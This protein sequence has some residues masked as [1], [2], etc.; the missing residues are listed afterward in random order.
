MPVRPK[1][2]TQDE[3]LGLFA[4]SQVGGNVVL[5]P[6]TMFDLV[7]REVVVGGAIAGMHAVTGDEQHDRVIDLGAGEE[8]LRVLDRV[9]R[10]DHVGAGLALHVQ[11]DSGHGVGPGGQPGVFG[12]VNDIGHVGQTHRG[13]VLER[14]DQV[15]VFSGFVH[16]Q[17]MAGGTLLEFILFLLLG[18]QTYGAPVEG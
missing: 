16:G 14:Q 1:P 10:G 18:W 7:G 5:E 12:V 2:L 15:G 17:Y 6:A 3:L 4:A 8:L 11:D 13:A 9:D